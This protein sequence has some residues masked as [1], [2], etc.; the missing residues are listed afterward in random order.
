[1]FNSLDH[2]AI[3]VSDSEEAIKIWRD[4]FGLRHIFN[5]KVNNGTIL[6][7]HFALGNTELQLVQPLVVEHP[8]Q[9]VLKNRGPGLHHFCLSVDNVDE[10]VMRMK[11]M[12]L[13]P[14]ELRPH[15][16]TQGKRALFLDTRSTGSVQVEITGA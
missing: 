11:E 4:R 13:L 8:L 5:E 9:Q 10:A 14:G 6:L 12:G 3:L 15:Q 2:V 16:G 1:M 7:T